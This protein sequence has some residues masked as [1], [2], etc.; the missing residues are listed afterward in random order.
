MP[1]ELQGLYLNGIPIYPS[2]GGHLPLLQWRCWLVE[3]SSQLRLQFCQDDDSDDEQVYI[4]MS[5]Q[6]SQRCLVGL[7]KKRSCP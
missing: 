2:Q 3:H 7:K 6:G 4:T 1:T 5:R